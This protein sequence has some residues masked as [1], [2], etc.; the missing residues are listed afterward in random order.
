MR[1][2]APYT[3]SFEEASKLS[4]RIRNILRSFPQVTTVANELGRP[5]DGTDPTGFFNDEFYVGL[6]PYSD[7]AWKSGRI[8]NKAELTADIQRQLQAFPGVIFN[9][10]Q[11]AE[12]A[13]DEALTGLKSALAVKIYGPAL[14]FLQ[15]KALDLKT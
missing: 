6:K 5:D 12:D 14:N 4:P 10:T 2:P 9:Y 15:S 13:V 11:P 1:A 3:I 7:S 8:H